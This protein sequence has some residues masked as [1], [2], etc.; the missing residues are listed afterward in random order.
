MKVTTHSIFIGI[1]LLLTFSS[2]PTLAQRPPTPVFVTIVKNVDFVDEVE[3]LGTL[4]SNENVEIMSTVTELVT[5]I[6]FTDGQRV[7]KG[8]ILVEMD[9]AEEIALQVEEAS[10]I[11]EAQK[12]SARLKSLFKRDVTSQS[13]L[14]EIERELDTAKARLKATQSRINQHILV[15]PFDGVVGLRNISVGAL[16]QPGTRIATL[17]ED[18][19]MKLDFSVP[20]VFIATLKE[21]TAIEAR[22]SAYPNQLFTGV[23][24]SVDTRID[25]LTRSI[26]ARALLQNDERKLKPGLLMRIVLKK[27][28]RQVIAI[29]EES[30]INRGNKTFVLVINESVEPFTVQEQEVLLGIRRKGEVEIVSGLNLNQKVVI[31]GINRAKPGSPVIIKGIETNNESLTELLQQKNPL[32]NNSKG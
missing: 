5:H 27:N 30:I 3:A 2:T 22:T 12:K 16:V 23:I 1:I 29:P 4:Q 6:N 31:H 9:A 14:D 24:G 19:V 13:A 18:S 21:G 17:D 7:Q 26:T 15:A 25:P 20:E 11:E 32:N 10:R 28:P 8:D